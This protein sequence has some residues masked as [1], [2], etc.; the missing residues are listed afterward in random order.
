[1]TVENLGVQ[2][3]SFYGQGRLIPTDLQMIPVGSLQGKLDIPP[4]GIKD[5][6]QYSLRIGTVPNN[7]GA[8]DDENWYGVARPQLDKMGNFSIAA[9]GEGYVRAFVSGPDGR[10]VGR[11]ETLSDIRVK[12][13]RA[14]TITVPVSKVIPI[15]P[16]RSVR[17]RIVTMEDHNPAPNVTVKL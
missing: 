4:E 2:S 15:K 16:T 1:M 13:G 6:S 8:G 3:F 11:F 14:T 7:D 10:P 17:G 12:P 9:I 5:M